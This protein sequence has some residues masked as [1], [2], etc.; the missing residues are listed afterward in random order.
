MLITALALLNT[1]HLVTPDSH[2][3]PFCKPLF[4]GVQNLSWFVSFSD[5]FPFSFPPFLC[6]PPCYS[7]CSTYK[8]NHMIIVFLCLTY[9]TWHNP[10]Q[11]HPCRC[12]WWVFIHSDGWV[13]FHC[14]YGPH[15]FYPFICFRSSRVLPQ[16]GYCGQCNIGVHVPLL[17][18]TSVPLG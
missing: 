14:I 4:P 7:L 6:G 9:F 13:I 18:T 10:L 3:P 11:F 12:K 2:L 1:H 16:F 8:W 17:F 15:P 5:F